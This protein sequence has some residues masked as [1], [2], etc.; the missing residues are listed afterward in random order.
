M[1]TLLFEYGHSNVGSWDGK[2]SGDKKIYAKK[3]VITKE[4]E[5]LLKS[6]GIPMTKGSKKEFLYDFGDGWTA[7]V[8]MTV[9]TSRE[10]DPIVKRSGGFLGYDWMIDE[11]LKHGRILKRDERKI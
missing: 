3:V 1:R 9:G 2:W 8:I 10:F 6:L 5:E 11:I 4:K 7:K